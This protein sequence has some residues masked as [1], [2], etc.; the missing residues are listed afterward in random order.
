MST[1]RP[2]V[3]AELLR[4]REIEAALA[5]RSVVY[6]PLGSIEWHSHHL[7]IGLDGL[8][9]HG[10]CV[11]AA[12]RT[13]GIVMPTLYYGTGGGHTTYPWTFMTETDAPIADLLNQS[14][15][16]LADAR[17]EMAV[18]FTGHFAPEQIDLVDRL[19]VD[20]ANQRN[21]NVIGLSIHQAPTR[22]PPDHAGI[23]ETTLMS[24]LWPDRVD[25]T[26]LATLVDAPSVD[27][28]GNVHGNHRHDPAHPLHGIFGPDPRHFDPAAAAGLLD[29]VVIW[30]T[31]QVDA[32]DDERRPRRT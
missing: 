17:V 7:P 10:V 15:Q 6:L 24:A 23:F 12:A 30:T 5:E 2:T 18:L 22:L 27:P 9:A 29:D 16:R 25:L 1:N 26:Q 31:Q 8:N 4:P 19:T 11:E 14:L 32:A 20:W 21:L 13:G 28:D 3:R